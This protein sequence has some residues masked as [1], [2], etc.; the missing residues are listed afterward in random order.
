MHVA[1]LESVYVRFS[2]TE[3]Q[4]G[5]GVEDVV[6]SSQDIINITEEQL[7]QLRNY[8]LQNGSREK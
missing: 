8:C 6:Y 7:E 1:L 4:P 3:V 2:N 5:S